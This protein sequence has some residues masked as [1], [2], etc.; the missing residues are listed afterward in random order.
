[1]VLE[2][3]GLTEPALLEICRAIDLDVASIGVIDAQDRLTAL[4]EAIREQLPDDA[5]EAFISGLARTDSALFAS[6]IDDFTLAIEA[7][8]DWGA[9]VFNR[10][11][12]Y[13]HI[14]Q[15]QDGLADYR[16]YLQLSP[17]DIDPVVMLASERIGLLEGV[18]SVTPPSPTG[19]LA[20]GVMPGMGQ[21]Y[22]GRPVPGT[23]ALG[24]ALT[25]VAAGF[26][27]KDITTVCLNEVPAG[28][29]C[30]SDEIVEEITDLPYLW[31][32]VGI[33]AAV[34]IVAAVDAYLKA[35]RRSQEAA[36]II[37]PQ[38]DPGPQFAM[39][40]VSARGRQVDFNVLRVTFR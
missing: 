37:G 33:G 9:P 22:T 17:S 34:T 24:T 30:P 4:S 1:M 31:V 5:R 11:L 7:A 28:Q 38:P 36:A 8:P 25:S 27:I 3:L 15:I 2:D 26:L 14:G 13:E 32:G 29:P 20:L 39:P 18:A 23:I 12:V 40:S 21:Y 35:K 10:G 16:R 19:A 6:A